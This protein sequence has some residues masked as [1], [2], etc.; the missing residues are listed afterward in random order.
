M[1][2][3]GIPQGGYDTYVQGLLQ[4]SRASEQKQISRPSKPTQP[5][6]EQK[7]QKAQEGEEVLTLPLSFSLTHAGPLSPLRSRD[8]QALVDIFAHDQLTE[9]EAD[10]H[11]YLRRLYP[12]PCWDDEPYEFLQDFI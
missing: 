2:P 1:E 11:Q 3:S 5:L 4:F 8:I 6:V 12:E 7:R 9:I 10:I